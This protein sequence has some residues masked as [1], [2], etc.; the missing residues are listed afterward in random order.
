MSRLK[1]KCGNEEEIKHV[2]NEREKTQSILIVS[3]QH[4]KTAKQFLIEERRRQVAIM[5]A[6]G[7]TELEIASKLG[8]DNSTI[9]TDVK[10]DLPTVH[11]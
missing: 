7:M 10:V 4:R 2:Q 8:V 6:K 5:I 3:K 1:A 11:L 9:S